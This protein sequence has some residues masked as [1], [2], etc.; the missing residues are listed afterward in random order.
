[1]LQDLM[2]GRAV[3]LKKKRWWNWRN[4]K[5]NGKAKLKVKN[6]IYR[7]NNKGKIKKLNDLYRKNNRESHIKR[8]SEYYK[9][10][11]WLYSYYCAKYRCSGN[12]GYVKKNRK[13]L[14]TKEDFRTLW[15]RDKAYLMKTPS[16]D[17]I[18]NDGDYDIKNCRYIEH[19]ENVK[20]YHR[21]RKIA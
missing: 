10:Y 3:D 6:K 9:K 1:M 14:M 19:I 16:I 20:R 15:L 2:A 13:F 11:P 8:C 12:G 21:E 4:W 5:C 17:R 18:N 7:E